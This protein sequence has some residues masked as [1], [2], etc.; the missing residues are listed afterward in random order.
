MTGKNGLNLGILC[1][2]LVCVF[3][4]R[5]IEE[6]ISYTGDAHAVGGTIGT[7]PHTPLDIFEFRQKVIELLREA[8]GEL[9]EFVCSLQLLNGLLHVVEP[10]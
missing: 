7:C 4:L 6:Q 3:L 9:M 8:G 5:I 10:L 2:M 1:R